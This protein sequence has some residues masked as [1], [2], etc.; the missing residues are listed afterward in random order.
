MQKDT[1]SVINLIQHSLRLQASQPKSI[2][3][4]STADVA[5]TIA[6]KVWVTTK[7]KIKYGTSLVDLVKAFERLPHDL[8][9]KA[10]RK[11]NYCLWT[12]RLS[13]S[14]YRAKRV[15][16]LDGAVSRPIQ[17]TRG[18]TAGSGHATDELVCLMLD[19][20]D[21]LVNQSPHLTLTVYVDDLTLEHFGFH[22]D[23]IRRMQK[24]TASF[25]VQ[26]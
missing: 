2:V 11:H 6:H 16:A 21:L 20:C 17:A 26:Q 12:L 22:A 8:I 1:A 19:M 4:A 3:I 13:L 18:I 24:D 5:R 10:A 15:I 25:G 7:F 23:V 9:V 14:A